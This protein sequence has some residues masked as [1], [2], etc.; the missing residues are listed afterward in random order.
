LFKPLVGGLN[1][2]FFL[3]DSLCGIPLLCSI[4]HDRV[5]VIWVDCIQD[6]EEV[7]PARIL[8]VSVFVLEEH[9]EGLIILQ[10]LP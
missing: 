1:G 5:Q 10:I 4:L 3:V 7:F 6:I 2:L 9:F 8:F